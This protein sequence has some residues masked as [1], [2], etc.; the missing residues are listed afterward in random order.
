MDIKKLIWLLLIIGF[1]ASIF[2]VAE[3]D[4]NW[5]NCYAGL[6][7]DLK[8]KNQDDS[9]YTGDNIYNSNGSGQT[10]EQE[11]IEGETVVYHVEVENDGDA[12]D[13][14]RIICSAGNST[15][16][17]TY[18]DALSGGNEMT[19]VAGN[20]IY[21][22][23][24]APGGKEYIRIEVAPI[25]SVS[26]GDSY[27]VSLHAQPDTPPRS[28]QD[29]I[30]AET[31]FNNDYNPDLW[32]SLNQTDWEEGQF[33][34]V[35]ELAKREEKGIFYIKIENA[36]DEN[37]SYTISDSLSGDWPIKYF[38]GSTE[39]SSGW[40]TPTVTSGSYVIIKGEVIPAGDSTTFSS[41]VTATSVDGPSNPS[42]SAGI[43]LS[44]ASDAMH[45]TEWER[46]E[47]PGN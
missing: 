23:S 10:K 19:I 44:K 43:N 1:V 29:K 3:I 33:S 28:D 36:G 38:Y 24:I 35:V 14:V 27:T 31:T 47:K 11:V 32:V 34:T 4:M 7:P 40:E 22:G 39:I 25:A 41:Q 37:D 42:A 9:S 8:I 2:F 13:I 20:K 18:Y 5:G 17:V 21:T 30:K 15:W 12:A 46:L 45:P 16:D 26:S 6:I